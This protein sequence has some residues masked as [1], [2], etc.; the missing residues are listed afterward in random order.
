MLDPGRVTWW[1]RL[2]TSVASGQRSWNTRGVVEDE[3][4]V[5]GPLMIGEMERA[6]QFDVG[7]TEVEGLSLKDRYRLVGN[8]FHCGVLRHILLCYVSAKCLSGMITRDDPRG[9]GKPFVENQDGPW[10]VW[11]FKT[12]P[13]EVEEHGSGCPRVA[14]SWV[15]FSVYSR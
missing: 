5:K 9:Q 3:W 15:S 12:A 10:A 14:S 8:S 1:R 2:A 11:G 4:G 13:R 7:F 6:M